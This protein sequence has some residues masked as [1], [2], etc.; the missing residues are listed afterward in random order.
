MAVGNAVPGQVFHFVPDLE[1]Q[2]VLVHLH[3]PFTWAEFVETRFRRCER[4]GAGGRSL[5]WPPAE[6]EH[7]EAHGEELLNSG[8][9]GSSVSASLAFRAPED[10]PAKGYRVDGREDGPQ[11]PAA[12]RLV[13]MPALAPEPQLLQNRWS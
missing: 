2:H 9:D 13:L 12:D 3:G 6:L 1:V 7:S 8:W 11:A 4:R 10:S 5:L